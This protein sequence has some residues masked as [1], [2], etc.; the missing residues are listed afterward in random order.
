MALMVNNHF[1]T[2]TDVCIWPV[3]TVQFKYKGQLKWAT[4]QPPFLPEPRTNNIFV[5]IE[6]NSGKP[7][8]D[9]PVVGRYQ[10]LFAAITRGLDLIRDWQ[11]YGTSQSTFL[12][13]CN[14]F[15]VNKEAVSQIRIRKNQRMQRQTQVLVVID[16]VLTTYNAHY[17]TNNPTDF[18]VKAIDEWKMN[19]DCIRCRC[20]YFHLLSTTCTEVNEEGMQ[21][22]IA[23]PDQCFF[24]PN[25]IGKETLRA[26]QKCRY[27]LDIWC[28][29]DEFEDLE[30]T[31]IAQEDGK[32]DGDADHI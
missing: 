27:S 20:K 2:R 16:P 24:N 25:T 31:T 19:H 14:K 11:G 29:D 4:I 13:V 18:G 23:D 3:E 9:D 28:G 15:K 32:E 12:S 21:F 17:E 1:E 30:S 7:C 8:V 5:K 26:I 10:H 6:P 22:G